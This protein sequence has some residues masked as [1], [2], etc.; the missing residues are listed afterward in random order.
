MGHGCYLWRPAF[1]LSLSKD[2]RSRSNFDKISGPPATRGD[3]A[4]RSSACAA[5]TSCVPSIP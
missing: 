3:V 2:V 1:V 5:S 4:L